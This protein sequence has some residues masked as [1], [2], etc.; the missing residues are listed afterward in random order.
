MLSVLSYIVPKAQNIYIVGAADC[1]SFKENSKYIYLYA[2]KVKNNKSFVWITKNKELYKYLVSVNLPVVFLYSI[3]G[4]FRILR[5][6]YLIISSSISDVSYYSILLGNFKIIQ[7]WHGTPLKKID[8]GSEKINFGFWQKFVKKI[9]TVVNNI[10]FVITPSRLDVL[11]LSKIFK[12]KK[13]FVTGYPRN[14]IFFKNDYKF[15]DYYFELHLNKYDKVLFYLPTFRDGQKSILFLSE[16]NIPKLNNLLKEKN[17]VLF[18]KGHTNKINSI[19][20]SK[21]T[22]IIDVTNIVIDPQELLIYIDLLITDYS[23]VIFDFV[24]TNKPIILYS[25]DYDHYLKNCRGLYY[26]YYTELVGPFAKT[27]SEL[28]N[29]I[30]T[31]DIWSK[32]K[33]Y[34]KKYAIF[35]KRFNY[36]IDGESS[37]RVYNKILMLSK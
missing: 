8:A 34:L 27:E 36:Y 17:Y 21:Y 30:S 1:R 5:S 26:N 2:N 14:D 33:N 18:I 29:L 32:N 10:Y 11:K 24:L 3:N 25:F 20:F 16:E 7:L 22:N 6:K 15:Y 35:K 28:L 31:I 23:S 37:K 12:T 4:F 19:D 13:V 9:N